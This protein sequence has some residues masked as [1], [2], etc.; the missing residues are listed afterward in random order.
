[1]SKT[2]RILL[3]AMALVAAMV[4]IALVVGACRSNQPADP[5]TGTQWQ[6]QSYANPAEAGG[7]SSPL[8]GTQL[9]AEF[10]QDAST[11]ESVVSGSAGCNNYTAGYTVDGDSV[12]I[13]D[14]ASTM[15]FCVPGC[16]GTGSRRFC[17]LHR[18]A[19]G[20][21]AAGRR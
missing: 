6:V 11:K 4:I 5:L 10:A 17:P 9:T 16:P 18:D 19:R 20:Y 1:M 8:G 3:G 21:R 7:L 13:G 14:A 12:S 2:V 15:M